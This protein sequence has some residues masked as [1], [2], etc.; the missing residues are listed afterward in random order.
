MAFSR[1]FPCA[2]RLL[3]LPLLFAVLCLALG[4]CVGLQQ[5][6]DSTLPGNRPASWE[7]KSLGV[8]M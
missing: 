7:G 3:L 4:S 6:P 8:P 5:D 1:L 2:L